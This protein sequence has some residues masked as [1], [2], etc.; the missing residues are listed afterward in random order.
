MMGQTLLET[1]VIIAREETKQII[2]HP[3]LMMGM[4]KRDDDS[5][6]NSIG[7]KGM[8]FNN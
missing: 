4:G 3:G 1:E 7:S 2:C 8:K 6:K 5:A